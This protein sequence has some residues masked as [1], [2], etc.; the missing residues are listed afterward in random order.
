MSETKHTPGPWRYGAPWDKP[1]GG[2]TIFGRHV[3]EYIA[4]VYAGHHADDSVDGPRGEANARLIAAAPDLL[5][6]LEA[7]VAGDFEAQGST[8]AAQRHNA[9]RDAARAAIA[10]ARGE[11]KEGA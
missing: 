8:L 2:R 7:Y 3:D 9:R 11:T 6:A 5:A 1:N 10:K 4:D